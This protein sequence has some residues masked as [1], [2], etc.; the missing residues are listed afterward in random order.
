[1]RPHPLRIQQMNIIA[2]VAMLWLGSASE[3]WQALADPLEPLRL[4]KR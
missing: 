3:H 1:M 2:G 4:E